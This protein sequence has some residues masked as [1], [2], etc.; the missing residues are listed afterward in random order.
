MSRPIDNHFDVNI[1][2]PT[3]HVFPAY[4]LPGPKDMT[5]LCDF[6]IYGFIFLLRLSETDRLELGLRDIYGAIDVLSMDAGGTSGHCDGPRVRLPS[7]LF[8][9]R[10]T[11]LI[12]YSHPTSTKYCAIP[13]PGMAC[14]ISNPNIVAPEDQQEDW[15]IE[16]LY[17]PEECQQVCLQREGCKA[18]RV[19]R[20]PPEDP[21]AWNCEIFNLGLGVNGSNVVSASK[22]DQWWD[23][24][25]GEH[26]PTECISNKLSVLLIPSPVIQPSTTP[27][28]TLT[29][30]TFDISQPTSLSIQNT[31]PPP[32]PTPGPTLLPHHGL[33][34]RD[35][36]FPDFLSDVDNFYSY[37]YVLAACS[38][39]ISSGLPPVLSTTT[40]TIT[41]W[42][43]TTTVS[44]TFE[45]YFTVTV[46]PRSTTVFQSIN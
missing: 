40:F 19:M 3:N 27:I 31:V 43:A 21:I 28:P 14:G 35:G 32:D 23:R 1:L 30:S 37:P 44:T 42:N 38:C 4:E 16:H 5:S 34:K 41:K 22:G 10:D 25:C 9:T 24:N 13:S 12:Y 26:L 11:V 45:D 6:F 18:Y 2:I 17:S 8:H 15:T 7:N 29:K 46:T 33:T 36:P 20:V 39:L